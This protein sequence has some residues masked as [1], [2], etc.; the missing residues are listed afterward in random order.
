VGA[1]VEVEVVAPRVTIPARAEVGAVAGLR[2]SLSSFGKS[3]QA[4]GRLAGPSG[5]IDLTA[6]ILDRSVR[7]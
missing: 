2:R 5:E 6:R 1:V 4:R 3:A 7:P